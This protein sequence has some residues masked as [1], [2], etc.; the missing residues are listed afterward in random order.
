MKHLIRSIL[1]GFHESRLRKAHKIIRGH[2]HLFRRPDHIAAFEKAIHEN[3]YAKGGPGGR[4]ESLAPLALLPKRVRGSK[5]CPYPRAP[6]FNEMGTSIP[7]Q[8]HMF[9][10]RNGS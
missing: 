9:D 6:S 1:R 10:F 3:D 7:Q 2:R 8:H 5:P 4:G